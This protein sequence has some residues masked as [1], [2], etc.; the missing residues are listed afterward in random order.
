VPETVTVAAV[1]FQVYVESIAGRRKPRWE[2]GGLNRIGGARRGLVDAHLAEQVC[3]GRQRS[4]LR[5]E[6]SAGGV[7]PSPVGRIGPVDDRDVAIAVRTAVERLTEVLRAG[8]DV[9]RKR[10]RTGGESGQTLDGSSNCYGNIAI[11][12]GANAANKATVNASGALLTA[13]TG[14]LPAGTN[15]LGKMGIDQTTPGTTNAVQAT[16]S[17]GALRRPAMLST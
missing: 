8:S 1:V 16:T 5:R 14:A 6:K 12:D 13:Q 7:S 4:G 2:V 10:I 9:D 11:V 17:N 15:L 3:P